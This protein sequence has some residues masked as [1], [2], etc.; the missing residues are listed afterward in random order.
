MGKLD[1]KVAIVTGAASGMGRATAAL[2]ASEGAKV[3]VADV[4][5]AGAAETVSQIA[6]AGGEAVAVVGDHS[7]NK[8]VQEIV[9]TALSNYGRVDALHNN[10][11]ILRSYGSIEE[12]PEDVW[13]RVVDVNLTGYF[14]MSR[15]VLPLMRAGGGAIV[16]TA[17][18]AAIHPYAPG[19]AYSASKAGVLSLTTA[20]AEAGAADG[21][22]VNAICPGGVD[23]P[24][25]KW[26]SQPVPDDRSG[27]GLLDPS[28]VARLVLYFVTHPDMTGQIVAANWVE[29]RPRYH[30]VDVAVTERE[31]HID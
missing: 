3:V 13:R 30:F 9:G 25:L 18:M 29:G 1:G 21:V 6:A 11:G 23:T 24:I 28:D 2:L 22:R 16:N 14:L 31:L 8:D 20:F 5:D 17:S 10:A 12:H 27:M 7:V 4:D 15:A 19:P 26:A